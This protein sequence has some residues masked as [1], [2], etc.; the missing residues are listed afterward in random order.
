MQRDGVRHLNLMEF[1]RADGDLDL[2]YAF[3]GCYLAYVWQI[4]GFVRT[5]FAYIWQLVSTT[6]NLGGNCVPSNC[7]L[8]GMTCHI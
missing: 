6:S 7:G 5:Y 4:L 8:S 2:S 1:L 3:G